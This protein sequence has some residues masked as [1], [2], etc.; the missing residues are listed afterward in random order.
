MFL[1]DDLSLRPGEGTDVRV[2]AER[3]LNT[4]D[5]DDLVGLTSTSGFGPSVPEPRPAQS[6]AL[7]STSPQ[8]GAPTI[9]TM[10]ATRCAQRNLDFAVAVAWD[11]NPVPGPSR[12]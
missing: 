11:R 5:P 7:G 12:D 3:F 9:P 10:A 6:D 2:A 1:I 8:S 4:L